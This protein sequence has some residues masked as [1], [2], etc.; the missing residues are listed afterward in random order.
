M[1]HL[2]NLGAELRAIEKTKRPPRPSVESSESVNKAGFDTFDT[3]APGPFPEIGVP[4]S[5]QP[6]R[7]WFIQTGSRTWISASFTPPQTIREV[8][9]YWHPE[10]LAIIEEEA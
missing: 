2:D 4:A 9:D 10:A 1:T 7:L 5:E 8:R 6:R 3:A